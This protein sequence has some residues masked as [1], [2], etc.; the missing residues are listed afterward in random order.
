MQRAGTSALTPP[1]PA[2]PF[3]PCP[4]Q[5]GALEIVEAVAAQ[6]AA[7]TAAQHGLMA[8]PWPF[9]LAKLQVVKATLRDAV[10]MIGE[11]LKWH[12]QQQQQ[13]Q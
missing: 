2:T 7:Q 8:V 4:F 12:W 10:I 6:T 5:M 9:W 3:C 13:Q 11:E 1:P